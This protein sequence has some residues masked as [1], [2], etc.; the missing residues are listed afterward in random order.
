MRPSQ[1]RAA[2]L[3]TVLGIVITIAIV[4]A[5]SQQPTTAPDYLEQARTAQKRGDTAAAIVALKAHVQASPD[6]T[7]ARLQLASLLRDTRPDEALTIL[8]RVPPTDPQWTTALQQ[9]AVLHL[10]AGRQD[11]A[12]A[13]LKAIVETEP[14][15]FGAQLSLAEI[16][17][18]QKNFDAALPH[19]LE[20]A[21]LNPNRAET[22][23]LISD[24]Y[25]EL[26]NHIAMIAPLQAALAVNSDLY[27]A[28][29]NLAYV[30][31]RLGQLTEADEHARWCLQKNPRE[32]PALR[33]LASIARNDGRFEEADEWLAKAMT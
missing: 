29:L 8:Q 3:L 1:K 11:H 13:V 23:L 25:D 7:E 4:I 16:Y 15:N 30:H 9:V 20:A 22:F 28:H 5:V 33:I 32:V 27:A 24:I 14:Q 17:F 18:N 2:A 19:A 12:A 21:R 10:L 26:H 6:S 31:H